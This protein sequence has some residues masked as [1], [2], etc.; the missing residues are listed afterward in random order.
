[1]PVKN[2]KRFLIS[3]EE[4]MYFIKTSYGHLQ[5][6]RKTAPMLPTGVEYGVLHFLVGPSLY[7]IPNWA[8]GN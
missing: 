2:G 8:L 3:I 7:V 4:F 1:V 5:K 6:E